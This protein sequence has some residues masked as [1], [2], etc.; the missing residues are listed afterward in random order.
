MK[1]DRRVLVGVQPCE[2]EF[3]FVSRNTWAEANPGQSTFCRAAGWDVNEI[4]GTERTKPVH[5][6]CSS[7]CIVPV[8]VQSLNGTLLQRSWTGSLP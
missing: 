1:G 6:S 4:N 8:V 7:C 2:L 3:R 5:E